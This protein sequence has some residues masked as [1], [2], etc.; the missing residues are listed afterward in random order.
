MD[1]KGEL[2]GSF[3]CESKS[4]IIYAITRN[5]YP[6]RQMR[7]KVSFI[8]ELVESYPEAPKPFKYH[9]L[10][11][12]TWLSHLL[13]RIQ[14]EHMLNDGKA[15]VHQYFAKQKD[16]HQ[17]FA[18]VVIALQKSFTL[19]QRKRDALSRFMVKMR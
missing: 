17:D 11:T 10:I 8:H 14:P 5:E 9:G 12:S 4:G 1:Y 15:Q 3:H 2:Y 7:W 13:I 18:G 16:L 19:K 6:Y